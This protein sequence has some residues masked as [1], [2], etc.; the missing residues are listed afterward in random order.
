MPAHKENQYAAKNKG[1]D[2]ALNIKCKESDKKEW[3]GAA[4]HIGRNLT[5]WVNAKLN[6]ALIEHCKQVREDYFKGKDEL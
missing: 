6:E 3:K 5:D 4:D 2:S 1:F